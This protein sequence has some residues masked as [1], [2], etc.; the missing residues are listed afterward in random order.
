MQRPLEQVMLELFLGHDAGIDFGANRGTTYPTSEMSIA[1]AKEG[2][3]LFGSR[4]K[5]F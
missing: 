4:N 1:S 2:K 3:L 5:Y